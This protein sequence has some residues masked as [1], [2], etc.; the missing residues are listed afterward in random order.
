MDHGNGHYNYRYFWLLQILL[1]IFMQQ[2][3]EELV[4]LI[5]SAV[6]IVLRFFGD[7]PKICTYLRG[8]KSFMFIQLRCIQEHKI[9]EYIITTHNTKVHSIQI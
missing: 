6:S 5:C 9:Q 3:I 8:G 1:K 2:H 4:K 7:V